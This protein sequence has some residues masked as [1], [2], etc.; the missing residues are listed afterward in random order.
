MLVFCVEKSKEEGGDNKVYSGV[1][2]SSILTDSATLG[3]SFSLPRRT[4]FSCGPSGLS[5]VVGMVVVAIFEEI[6]VVNGEVLHLN[7]NFKAL[8]GPKTRDRVGSSKR[9][10]VG[11]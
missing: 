8:V 9:T 4:N 7:Y 6:A 1:P 2:A 10:T 11:L 3:V 5:I